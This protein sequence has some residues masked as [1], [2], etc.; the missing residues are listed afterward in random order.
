[1]GRIIWTRE[2]RDLESNERGL[3]LIETCQIVV[4]S[5][6]GAIYCLIV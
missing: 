4:V 3:W 1:M 2:E 6:L 5:G